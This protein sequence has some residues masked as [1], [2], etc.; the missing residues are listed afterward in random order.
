MEL[1]QHAT[2]FVSRDQTI[3]HRPDAEVPVFIHFLAGEGTY[4]ITP[5]APSIVRVDLT[6]ELDASPVINSQGYSVKAKPYFE[7]E[8][9]I[10]TLERSRGHG[11][12]ATWD[13][14]TV[15]LAHAS[16]VAGVRADW[17]FRGA[18][19]TYWAVPQSLDNDIS[20]P[21][22]AFGTVSCGGT[23][24]PPA[25]MAAGG[26]LTLTA[27]LVDGSTHVLAKNVE[28]SDTTLPVH[29]VVMQT[30]HD[31]LAGTAVATTPSASASVAAQA[32]DARRAL[33]VRLAFALFLLQLAAGRLL[34]PRRMV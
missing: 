25:E 29:E 17:S 22:A 13:D 28:V 5:V 14:L 26:T 23:T 1:P 19:A 30:V 3:D 16:G 32:D 2:L 10:V 9:A 18:H 24:I 21:E 33:V 6:A 7:R 27:I 4:T 8:P 12:T 11:A 34:V 20:S 15:A 31:D